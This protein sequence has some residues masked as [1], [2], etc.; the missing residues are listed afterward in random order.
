MP[1]LYTINPSLQAPARLPLGVMKKFLTY[2]VQASLLFL[3]SCNT[4]EIGHSHNWDV[5]F[6]GE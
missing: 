2:D 5:F 4:L 3:L 6:L 1:S